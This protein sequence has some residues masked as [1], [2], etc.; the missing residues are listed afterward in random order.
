MKKLNKSQE[1]IQM[2]ATFCQTK[3][4]QGYK[5]AI[6]DEWLYVS[7]EYLLKVIYDKAKS[8]QFRTIEDEGEEEL[9]IFE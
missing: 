4:G 9:N 2:K 6:N 1:V 5:I 8:C 3:A 7:K